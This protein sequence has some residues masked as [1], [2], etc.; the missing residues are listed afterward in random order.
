M[1][2][3]IKKYFGGLA[4]I[5]RVERPSKE[6]DGLKV[7]STEEIVADN[8]AFDDPWFVVRYLYTKDKERDTTKPIGYIGKTLDKQKRG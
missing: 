6:I 7:M 2:E 4:T 5:D 1:F 3:G 8:E